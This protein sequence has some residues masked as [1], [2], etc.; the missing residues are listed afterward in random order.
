MRANLEK[1]FLKI[2]ELNLNV[3]EFLMNFKIVRN[4]L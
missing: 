1:K 3:M 2:L 4:T